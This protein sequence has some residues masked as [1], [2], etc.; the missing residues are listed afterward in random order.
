L[1]RCACAQPHRKATL[2]RGSPDA[3]ISR[4]SIMPSVPL[5]KLMDTLPT[6]ICTMSAPDV[7]PSASI[8]R[9]KA[10]VTSNCSVDA[11]YVSAESCSH[12]SFPARVA[13]NKRLRIAFSLSVT[14]S[15]LF[16]HVIRWIRSLNSL[17]LLDGIPYLPGSFSLSIP[18]F[19]SQ[20]R[21]I[22]RASG[23]RKMF[24]LSL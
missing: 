23:L 5:Q 7:V 16:S 3:R 13:C 15:H 22:A 11:S 19:L 9:W 21:T 17:S 2:W 8:G 6:I 14:G 10:R 18:F 4:V 12:F 24:I 20:S 1:M